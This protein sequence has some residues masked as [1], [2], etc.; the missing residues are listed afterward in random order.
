MP[1]TARRAAWRSQRVALALVAAVALAGAGC[2]GLGAQPPA[3]GPTARARQI[4]A[5]TLGDYQRLAGRLQ[6]ASS[7]PTRLRLLGDLADRLQSGRAQL[8]QLEPPPDQRRAYAAFLADLDRLAS[9]LRAQRRAASRH[10]G[11]ALRRAAVTLRAANSA[12]Y[13]D[14][15]KVPALGSCLPTADQQ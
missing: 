9:G 13:A 3:N 15:A 7:L 2:G 10:D 11:A 6:D 1:T 14:S 12:A 5:S 4:C 8:A